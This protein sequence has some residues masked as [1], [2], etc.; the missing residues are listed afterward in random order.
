MHTTEQRNSFLLLRANGWS[1]RKI[2]AKLNIPKSTLFDWECVHRAQIDLLKSMRGEK[3]PPISPPKYKEDLQRV[4]SAELDALTGFPPAIES[5]RISL[6]KIQANS[7]REN[8]TFT[9]DF[10]RGAKFALSRSS[11]S[12]AKNHALSHLPTPLDTAELRST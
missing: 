3:L 6:S 7:T 9:D 1:L 11:T 12:D 5:A 4:H 10:D 8:G 2:S